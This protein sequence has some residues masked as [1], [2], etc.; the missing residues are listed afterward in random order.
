MSRTR[1]SSSG[2]TFGRARVCRA[3]NMARST[4][5]ARRKASGCAWERGA[6]AVEA[7]SADPERRPRAIGDASTGRRTGD[8]SDGEGFSADSKA[9]SGSPGEW[10]N[11][12]TCM[13][14]NGSGAPLADVVDEHEDGR[15]SGWASPPEPEAIPPSRRGPKPFVPDAEL[16][17]MIREDLQRSPFS[18]EGH[19]KVWARLRR[20]KGIR[21]SKN[22]VL[23][24]MRENRLLSPHRVR[25]ASKAHDGT[26][27]TERP[28][29]MWGT[30]GTRVLTAEMG[31]IWVFAVVEHWNAEC[32]DFHVAKCGDRFAAL[33]P[34]TGAV[35]RV[36]GAHGADVAQGLALRMDH[37][38]QY[39]SG[40]FLDEI[41]HM[42]IAPSPSLV[43][44]PQTNGVVERFFRT[45]KEQVFH[46]RVFRG[47]ED[48]R[49]AVSEFAKTYNDSWLM[50][51]LDFRSPRE[52]RACHEASQ[53]GVA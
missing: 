3:W 17:V 15:G 53:K 48:V 5:Y 20:Q 46:G 43:R 50:E 6:K 44:Q 38:S 27:C 31:W 36:Y 47:V 24:V 42:G 12:A 26:I 29:E 11:E 49:Q 37:G 35:S 51:K 14:S 30:D 28:N 18:G 32:L 40:Y 41:R 21:V 8:E 10:R 45:L 19:R 7:S 13:A 25:V 9:A 34:V 33:V 22:R 2:R 39:T 23:R 1:S 52:A 16:L 4:L